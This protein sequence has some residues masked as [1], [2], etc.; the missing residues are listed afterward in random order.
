MV[1]TLFS[2]YMFFIV[3]WMSCTLPSIA[4]QLNPF[5]G[6]WINDYGRVDINKCHKDK[7]K[8]YILTINELH[9][10]EVEGILKILSKTS[11]LLKLRK[12]SVVNFTL[13]K[14]ILTISIPANSLEESREYCGLRGYFDGEYTHSKD[15][16]SSSGVKLN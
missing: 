5:E 11:A 9:T 14:R 1:R 4:K 15:S 8:L 13:N 10:C 3:C 16:V 6:K 12:G 2:A 7:C